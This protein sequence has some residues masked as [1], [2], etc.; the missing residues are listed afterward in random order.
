MSKIRRSNNQVTNTKA[1]INKI[2]SC[3]LYTLDF[4][5]HEKDIQDIENIR[6]GVKSTNPVSK[7]KIYKIEH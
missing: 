1:E 2:L 5:I 3:R 6:K 4:D 7:Y